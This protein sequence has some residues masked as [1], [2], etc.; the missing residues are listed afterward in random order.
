MN[1][2]EDKATIVLDFNKIKEQLSQDEDLVDA[3]SLDF[4][5]SGLDHVDE[6]DLAHSDELKNS[7]RPLILVDLK[8]DYFQKKFK[9]AKAEFL[10]V[11][12]LANLNS[13]LKENSGNILAFYYNSDPKII[14]QLILQIKEKFQE[15]KLLIIAS[16]LSPEKASQHKA[17][18]YGVDAY[19]SDP[20]NISEFFEKIEKL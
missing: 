17:T 16:K 7:P 10:I 6:E 20:F 12:E 15:N 9:G 1:D 19:L 18:K 14:N 11:K 8:S 5:V 13:L 3:A 2:D 4:T